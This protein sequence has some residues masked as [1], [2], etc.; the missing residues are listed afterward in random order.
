ME[1][2]H[3]R[4]DAGSPPD[5]PIDPVGLLARAQEILDFR[6][7]RLDCLRGDLRAKRTER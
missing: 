2:E 4:I 7:E 5:G 3:L 6:R 1:L